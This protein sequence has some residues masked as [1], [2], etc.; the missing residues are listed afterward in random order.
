MNL[1]WTCPKCSR[2]WSPQTAGCG[3]CNNSIGLTGVKGTPINPVP[4]W[5][6]T[7]NWTAPNT[8]C[9]VAPPTAG[10]LSNNIQSMD[11][12]LR[13]S[14]QIS[15]NARNE[16]VYFARSDGT[17]EGVMPQGDSTS[18]LGANSNRPLDTDLE[19]ALV[20]ARAQA[21]NTSQT[22]PS[23]A[24]D[25]QTLDLTSDQQVTS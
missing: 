4:S 8:G 2:V 19:Q 15:A 6:G 22:P 16:T 20:A 5:G 25:T 3:A 23:V 18:V 13:A 21:A 9:A 14:A 11:A 17:S 24:E 1:G 7:P 10:V 12:N